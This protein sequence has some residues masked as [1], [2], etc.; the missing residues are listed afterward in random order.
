MLDSVLLITAMQQLRLPN[1]GINIPALTLGVKYTP[2][3]IVKEDYIRHNTSNK[4][5]KKFGASI[6]SGITYKEISSAGGPSYPIF[7]LT[8]A[9][10]YYLSKTNR[11]SLGLEYEYNRAAYV[12]GY[13]VFQFNNE[14]EARRRS[15]RIMLFVADEFLFGRIGLMIQM[16]FYLTKQPILAPY[17]IYNKWG[18][19]Y[20][21]KKIGNS[22]T[23]FFIGTQIKTH[24]YIAD[25]IS[26]NVG[27]T[28]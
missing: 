9:G 5:E 11:A 19:H 23:R 22:S 8:G 12:F 24:I 2:N 7:S 14:Q 16:G 1:Y 13:H 21:F 6:T 20:H 4:P 15:N 25:Y 3:P 28:F 10:M 18:F 27:A 26:F 17:P